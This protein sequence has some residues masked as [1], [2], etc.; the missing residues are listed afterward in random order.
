MNFELYL[1]A[2]SLQGRG[3]DVLRTRA[4]GVSVWPS[5]KVTQEDLDTARRFK[6]SIQQGGYKSAAEI[7]LW[8]GWYVHLL[9]RTVYVMEGASYP[10][11][12]GALPTPQDWYDSLAERGMY[13]G[14]GPHGSVS[15]AP[16]EKVTGI[17]VRAAGAYGLIGAPR[18]GEILR[19]DKRRT[20]RP[21]RQPEQARILV[22]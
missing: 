9:T 13:L 6:A 17:D 11:D 3:M 14:R 12:T 15:L 7:A 21:T 5:E 20:A 2:R 16:E 18:L 10:Q 22:P 19:T 4:G 8:T 1:W